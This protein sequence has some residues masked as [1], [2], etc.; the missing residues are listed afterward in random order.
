M[1]NPEFTW[2]APE[3]FA[4][5]VETALDGAAIVAARAATENKKN[6]TDKLQTSLFENA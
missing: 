2:D 6:E 3:P 4:L 1:N 5:A